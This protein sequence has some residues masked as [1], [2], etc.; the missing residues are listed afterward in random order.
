[1][2]PF[3]LKAPDKLYPYALKDVKWPA[4]I[5]AQGQDTPGAVAPLNSWNGKVFKNHV[6]VKRGTVYYDPSY[7]NGPFTQG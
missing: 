3:P 5:P 7:G 4:G 6:L 2:S 1:M